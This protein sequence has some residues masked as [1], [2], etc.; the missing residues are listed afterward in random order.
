MKWN[1]NFFITDHYLFF[2]PATKFI[3]IFLERFC[4]LRRLFYK[5]FKQNIYFITF[6]FWNFQKC[7]SEK[8]L[9]PL[10]AIKN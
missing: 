10:E 5:G 6:L 1:Q 7:S 9:E 3:L 8:E 4:F 2:A